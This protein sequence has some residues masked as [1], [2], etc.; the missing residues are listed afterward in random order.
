MFVKVSI[1]LQAYNSWKLDF[2]FNEKISLINPRTSTYKSPDNPY[3]Q[4]NTG[5]IK[6]YSLS[7][8]SIL[9]ICHHMWTNIWLIDLLQGFDEVKKLHGYILQIHKGPAREGQW[10][11]SANFAEQYQ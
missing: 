8:I 1:Q 5:R 3:D 4:I 11:F 10:F 7:S 6:L 9:L 2:Y